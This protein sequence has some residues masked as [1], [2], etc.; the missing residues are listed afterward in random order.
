MC[1]IAL[2]P[3]VGIL[4]AGAGRRAPAARW[5]RVT[6]VDVP[7]G[8][9][10]SPVGRVA[11]L[12]KEPACLRSASLVRAADKVERAVLGDHCLGK[13][14]DV[15]RVNVRVQLVL[16]IVVCKRVRMRTAHRKAA[17]VF[18]GVAMVGADVLVLIMGPLVAARQVL[19]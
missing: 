14:L 7:E 6:A 16:V 17:R 15:R 11:R 1:E 5:A 9:A 13:E 10:D 18:W 2:L 3:V 12:L 4:L 8:A 19:E